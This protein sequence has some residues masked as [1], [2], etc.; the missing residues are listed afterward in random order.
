MQAKNHKK[1]LIKIKEDIAKAEIAM[2]LKRLREDLG[3]TQ[4]SL[5]KEIGVNK[6]EYERLE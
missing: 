4:E 3:H 2:E 6:R 1:R 5:A